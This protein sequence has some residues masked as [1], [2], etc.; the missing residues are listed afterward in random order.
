[1]N[2]HPY[3]AIPT[4]LSLTVHAS[5]VT[6]VDPYDNSTDGGVSDTAFPYLARATFAGVDS[7]NTSVMPGAWSFSDLD[8]AKNQD[9]GWGHAT[10]W[11][12]I[13]LTENTAFSITMTTNSAAAQPGF[14]IYAGESL[15]DS[16]DDLH[17]YSNN[18]SSLALNDPWNTSDE[19]TYLDN[20]FAGNTTS[21]S[22]TFQ[23]NAGLYTVGFGNAA[24]STTSPQ[25]IP[26]QL[27]LS[28]V[29]EPSGLLL[30]SV[31]A[32]FLL[33]RRRA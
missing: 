27:S 8:P 1:M 29:P 20:A 15:N 3:L 33:R 24:D 32:L 22:E 26:Y 11:I 31:G 21:L 6:V 17:T 13:E 25:A 19:L 2:K 9:R 12:L 28:A 5:A 18:G 30:T 7:Y 10:R 23:L 14:V 16:P 4:L